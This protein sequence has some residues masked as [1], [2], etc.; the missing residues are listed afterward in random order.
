MVVAVI[1]MMMV[2]MSLMY[3]VR[4]VA[5][6]NHRVVAVFGSLSTVQVPRML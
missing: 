3:V 4:M 2:Q 1:A 6:R 5:V